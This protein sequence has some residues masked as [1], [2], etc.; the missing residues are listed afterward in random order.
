MDLILY[1]SLLLCVR[2]TVKLPLVGYDKNLR[3]LV[4]NEI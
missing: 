1:F 2:L 4:N 3:D